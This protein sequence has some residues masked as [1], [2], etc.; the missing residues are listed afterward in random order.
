MVLTSSLAIRWEDTG[1]E[2]H[3]NTITRNSFKDVKLKP[4]MTI[5]P[6]RA[7]PMP[8]VSPVAA[9]CIR[10]STYRNRN[11]PMSSMIK[12][13]SPHKSSPPPTKKRSHSSTITM[14]P[15]AG[16]PPLCSRPL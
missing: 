1:E 9:A 2:N 3:R 6:S 10:F 16:F 12:V 14:H 15:S 5:S 11:T 4:L 8:R 7:K 13:P